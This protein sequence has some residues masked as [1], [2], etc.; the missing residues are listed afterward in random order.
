[1]ERQRDYAVTHG[2]TVKGCFL[3]VHNSVFA[4]FSDTTD[5]EVFHE[6]SRTLQH[7]LKTAAYWRATYLMQEIHIILTM[8]LSMITQLMKS[9][10]FFFFLEKDLL[11]TITS[12]NY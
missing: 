1:M 9:V 6:Q 11:S 2:D 8:C 10:L 7:H 4:P 3:K 5:T 12:G